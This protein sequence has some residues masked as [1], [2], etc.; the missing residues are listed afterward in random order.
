MHLFP[1]YHR[2]GLVTKELNLLPMICFTNKFLDMLID[3][4]GGSFFGISIAFL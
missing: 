3:L 2:T 1:R 4:I